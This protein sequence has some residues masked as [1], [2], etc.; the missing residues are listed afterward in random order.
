MKHQRKTTRAK[1]G[2]A[3]ITA[4][5]VSGPKCKRK[6]KRANHSARPAKGEAKDSRTQVIEKTRSSKIGI[7]F[8]ITSPAKRAALIKLRDAHPGSSV[9]AQQD[10]LEKA[11]RRWP[12][13][14]H[15]MWV[16]GLQDG[17]A[18]IYGLRQR[19]LDITKVWV[20][21][22]TD[23]GQRHVVGLYSLRRGGTV[24]AVFPDQADLFRDTERA[25]AGRVMADEGEAEA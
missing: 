4:P 15:E 14:F 13:T 2:E 25:G 6:S 9:R 18:R 20:Y 5:T 22:E 8:H 21:T 24:P 7:P 11:L 3:R 12:L 16:L 1:N 23:Y 10:R 19:G 17:R